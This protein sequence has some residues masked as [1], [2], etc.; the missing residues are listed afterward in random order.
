MAFDLVPKSFWAFPSLR[1][2][3]DDEDWLSTL[4]GT[5]S[6]LSISEDDK[7]VYVEANLP[8]LK[9]D[10]IDV[11]YHKGELWIKGDRKEEE[12]DKNRKFYRM[13][14]S[15][16][17]YRIIVPGDVDTSKEPDASYD[18]GIMT[19]TFKKLDEIK[20]KKIAVK[21]G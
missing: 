12:K 4:P 14:S 7:N 6:G 2:W 9:A 10:D 1:P 5:P 11:T 21:K 3:F 16:Y 13:A 18:N 8:G 15:S 20:P 19:V 17:S